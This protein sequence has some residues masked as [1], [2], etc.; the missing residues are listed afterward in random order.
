MMDAEAVSEAVASEL[1]EL[2]PIADTPEPQSQE[3]NNPRKRAADSD[4][5]D[6]DDEV[7][8]IVNPVEQTSQAESLDNG[9][10]DVSEKPLSK[11][12]QRKL[13][14]RQK[15]AEQKEYRRLHRK[16]K[17]HA[18]QERKRAEAAE[19]Q[20]NGT[21]A[22]SVTAVP[23]TPKADRVQVPVTFVIDCDFEK[24][25]RENELISLASQI[26]RSYAVNKAAR[27]RAY[28]YISG[29]KGALKRRFEA[30]LS[31]TQLRWNGVQFVEGGFVEA[32]GKALN[33]M[34][35]PRGGEV[36]DVL[37]RGDG[38]AQPEQAQ[39]PPL[40]EGEASTDAA[41]AENHERTESGPLDR[42]VYLTADSPD[43]LDCLEPYTCYVIGGLVD[44]NREKGLCYRRAVEA[45]VRT[46]KL[47]IGEFMQMQHRA[48][49]ATNHVVE[50]LSEWL[51]TG[52]WAKAFFK[53]IPKRKGGVLREQAA[54]DRGDGGDEDV[55]AKE[56]NNEEGRYV[57][58]ADDAPTKKSPEGQVKAA[59]VPVDAPPDSQVSGDAI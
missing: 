26:V 7:D 3:P 21:V 52:D 1:Q 42:I 5:E 43:I 10:E 53:V 22:A 38:A 33:A 44:K 2:P 46:A 23:R 39:E 16:D 9:A 25:M 28:I 36:V 48:V 24:Y 6:D 14:K 12:Q 37:R 56:Q 54:Q 11:N 47:P 57:I 35:G 30:E 13:R 29:W 58:D 41:P 51:D 34:K 8:I 19:A 50:I 40:N 15:I 20:A 17:K 45:G 55:E 31:N 4:P 49:L 32:G 27:R 18:R 59:E